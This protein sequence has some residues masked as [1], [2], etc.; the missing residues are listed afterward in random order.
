MALSSAG[1]KERLQAGMASLHFYKFMKSLICFLESPAS[2]W[3]SRIEKVERGSTFSTLQSAGAGGKGGLLVYGIP[4]AGAAVI[5][6][7]LRHR[8]NITAVIR[9]WRARH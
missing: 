9:R 5:T 2:K 8:T 6:I 3:Q 1:F 7:G 4:A